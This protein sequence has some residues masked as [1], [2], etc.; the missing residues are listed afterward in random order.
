MQPCSH[1]LLP[2]GE[3]DSIADETGRIFCCEGCRAVHGFISGEGLEDFYRRRQWDPRDSE[4][5]APPKTAETAPFEEL[6]R[7]GDG[8]AEMD[9]YVDGIRCASC[10]WLVEK[11]LSRTSGVSYARVNYATHKARVRWDERAVSLEKILTRIYSTGYAPKPYTESEQVLARKA[12]SRELLVRF[13]TAAFLSCQLMVYSVALYAGYF[14]GMDPGVRRLLQLIAMGLTI[15][16]VFYAGLPFFRNTL[17]GLRKFRFTM[18]SLI[19]V[20][21]G[22]AFLYSLYGMRTGGEVYFD[23][24]AMIITLVLLGRY[25]ESRAKGSASEALERLAELSPKK[26]TRVLFDHSRGITARETVDASALRPGDFVEVRPGEKLPADG[27]VLSGESTADESFITGESTPVPKSPGRQVIGG[28][29]NRF[30]SLVFEVGKTGRDTVL[31]RIVQSV[32]D[33]QASK[34]AIQGLADRIVGIFVP[35]ILVLAAATVGFHLQA[36]SGAAPAVMTGI[37]VLVI[38]CPCSLG[39]ATPLAVLVFTGKASARG[40]LVKGGQTAETASSADHVILDKTGTLTRG[41]LALVNVTALDPSLDRAG[42]LR[43]AASVESRS[44]HGL[45]AAIVEAAGGGPFDDVSGF[46]A[47]P[48]RGVSGVA[49]GR[50]VFLGNR[51]FML[52]SGLDPVDDARGEQ[53]LSAAEEGGD[54]VVFMGWDGAVRALFVISDRI[55]GEA[56]EAVGLLRRAGMSVSLVSGDH[57]EAT[58]SAADRTGIENFEAEASPERKRQII[59]GLQERGHT[60]IMV[61]DGINDAPALTEA[62]VGVAVGRGTDIAMESG[63]VVLTRNDLRLVPWLVDISR[64]TLR[65]MRQNVFWAFFYNAT[66]I[67]LAVMGVLHPIIAA[68]AMAASSLFVVANSLRIR[69]LGADRE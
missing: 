52:A 64:G 10:V 37:S 48:G 28:S 62:A 7:R 42:A 22:S 38:A 33:A 13:G 24:T 6:V 14:Q 17:A 41:S 63:D 29:I 16:V 19:V 12:E 8:D 21:S 30:G 67:P 50:H 23:T 25:L 56:N 45:G 5:V 35:A 44:E 55:R 57:R 26:A 54:T 69:S 15:P 3:A 43:T 53:V 61:G 4:R 58:A 18:D 66:A 65:I 1:C 32:E 27:V 60:V 11:V 46:R 40:L 51:A 31:A 59:A 47:V 68:A 20:G 49:G 9:V 2:C 36:G 34:P 39:L